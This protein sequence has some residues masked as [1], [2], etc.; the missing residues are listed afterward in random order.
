MEKQYF[1][2]YELAK[3][4]QLTELD[5]YYCWNALTSPK[6]KQTDSPNHLLIV[7][8]ETPQPDPKTFLFSLLPSAIINY[9]DYLEIVEAR[10]NSK[11]AFIISLLAIGISIAI[12]AAQIYY[13][14]ATATNATCNC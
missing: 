4:L 14:L 12:G 7:V 8:R 2:F 10:K 3:D 6:A 5:E 9:V 11:N 13:Q 1:T